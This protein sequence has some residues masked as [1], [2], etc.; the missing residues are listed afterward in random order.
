MSTPKAAGAALWWPLARWGDL[1]NAKAA[2]PPNRHS[3]PGALRSALRPR[4]L[5]ANELFPGSFYGCSCHRRQRRWEVKARFRSMHY[6]N[7]SIFKL[8]IKRTDELNSPFTISKFTIFLQ[9][10]GRVIIFSKII[11]RMSRRSSL[12]SASNAHCCSLSSFLPLN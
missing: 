9:N 1:G 2:T 11:S 8:Q 3:V 10:C 7:T 12:A 6:Q 5:P 4:P